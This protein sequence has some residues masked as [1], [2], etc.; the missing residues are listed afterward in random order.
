L[1]LLIAFLYSSLGSGGVSGYLAAM[2]WFDVLPN[3]AASS[4]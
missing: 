3:V 4:D 2:S 1:V